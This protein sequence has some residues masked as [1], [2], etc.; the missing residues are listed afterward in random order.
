MKRN[1]LNKFSIILLG[2]L[3]VNC[4]LNNDPVECPSPLTGDLLESEVGLVGTWKISG[5]TSDIEVDITNDSENN[6]NTDVYNQS[7]DCAKDVTYTFNE[8]RTYLYDTGSET[9]GCTKNTTFGTWQLN[10]DELLFVVSCNSLAYDIT[11]NEDRS[12]FSYTLS[13]DVQEVNGSLTSA[14]LTFTFTKNEG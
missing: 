4:D 10:Q 7:D 5:I 6:P 13:L 14:R 11:I 3:L 1:I 12:Q 2:V 8:N 9:D